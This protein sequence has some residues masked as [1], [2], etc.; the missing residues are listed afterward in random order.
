[1]PTSAEACQEAVVQFLCSPESYA[2]MTDFSGPVSSSAASVVKHISTHCAH[3]FLVDQQVYKIKRAIAYSY[4]DMSTLESRCM[5]CKRELELNKPLL[6][7]IYQRIVPITRESG[8]ELRIDGAGE[9]VEWAVQM[10]RFCE[11]EVLDNLAKNDHLGDRIAALAGKSVADYHATLASLAL[12]DGFERIEEVVV[13][14]NKELSGL[15]S[16][17]SE[18]QLNRF[19]QMGQTE[20]KACKNL[21]NTRATSGFV[22]RC[23]GDLHLRNLVMHDGIPMPF[24]ALEFDE[25]M[26]TTDVLYDLAFLLMDLDH[27]ALTRQSNIAF[28]QYL[29]HSD[30]RNLIAL[31]LLPLFLFCRAGIRAMTTAQVSLLDAQNSSTHANEATQYLKLAL[32]YLEPAP[33]R[34]FAIG[35]YSGSGKS[36]LSVRLASVLRSAPGAVLIRSDAERKAGQG[37]D[38]YTTLPDSHYTADASRH[39]YSLMAEKVALALDAGYS[40]LVDAVFLEQAQRKAIEDIASSKSI[41]FAGVWLDVPVHVLESR[42]VSRGND[43]SDATVS[44]LKRQLMADPGDIDWHRVDASLPIDRVATNL[45]KLF[46]AEEP[47]TTETLS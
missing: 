27:R 13:E 29:L 9:I 26:A 3:V 7:D 43:A 45:E 2:H 38:E 44:V 12:N 33:P 41:P 28:N 1:M 37:V 40:V 31:R 17:F 15:G 30:E 21:L 46:I 8:G 23:H 18:S 24:D 20:L 34:L 14:L 42:I 4:L 16:V 22:R 47:F 6:P 39:N 19:R 36:T 11:N 35:G 5:Y 25:R 32:T 10:K